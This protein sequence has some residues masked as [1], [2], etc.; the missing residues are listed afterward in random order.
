MPARHRSGAALFFLAACVCLPLPAFALNV[1]R[2]EG[3]WTLNPDSPSPTT[4]VF[5]PSV[6]GAYFV[7][8]LPIG[9]APPVHVEVR[10]RKGN[11]WAPME[12][13]L[14]LIKKPAPHRDEQAG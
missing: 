3:R 8:E 10:V 13:S 9:T 14:S 12:F 11:V 4:G 5:T 7:A 1:Q 6:D 2:L